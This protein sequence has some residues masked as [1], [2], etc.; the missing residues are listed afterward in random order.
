M[1]YS[2][3]SAQPSYTH[4]ATTMGKDAVPV[5]AFVGTAVGTAVGAAEGAAVGTAVGAAVGWA[6]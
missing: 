2:A 5:G 3:S 4:T 6:G 1:K